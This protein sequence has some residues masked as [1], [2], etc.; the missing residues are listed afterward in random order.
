M[1]KIFFYITSRLDLLLQL[2]EEN[3][4]VSAK[5][6]LS[7]SM[8]AA[9]YTNL[10]KS[11]AE[12]RL[13]AQAEMDVSEPDDGFEVADVFGELAGNLSPARNSGQLVS[14]RASDDKIGRRDLDA[15]SQKTAAAVGQMRDRLLAMGILQVASTDPID[16]PP[17]PVRNINARSLKLAIASNTHAEHAHGVESDDTVL[18]PPPPP[19]EAGVR[20]ENKRRTAEAVDRMRDNLRG[21]GYLD[22]QDDKDDETESTVSA[23]DQQ[24]G[25]DG[26]DEDV[27]AAL[28]DK[29]QHCSSLLL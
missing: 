4:T 29:T 1:I 7:S 24:N 6:A 23:T 27:I 2:A 16:A 14:D 25:L 13:P 19:Y 8:S 3:K 9:Y 12:G 18:M 20:E 11:D 21:M 5:N 15:R 28:A 26:L 17:S 22:K 10:K